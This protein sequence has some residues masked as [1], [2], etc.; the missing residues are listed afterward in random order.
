LILQRD[1]DRRACKAPFRK[2]IIG[3][4]NL[5]ETFVQADLQKT[6]IESTTIS[7]RLDELA[8]QITADYN[9]KELTVLAVLS[10]SLMFA[11][12][13]LRRI[14]L[15]LKLVFVSASSYHG[16]TVTTGN[17]DL[18]QIALP[19]VQGRHIL[20]IDDILDSGL[21]LDAISRRLREQEPQT[22]RICVLLRKQKQRLRNIDAD[23][24]GFDIGDEFVVGYGL[25]YQERYRNLP[26]IGV[27]KPEIIA[28]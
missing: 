9:G 8:A 26:F 22:V 13:L 12:D 25:D 16:G 18:G 3:T 21:T 14:P 15:A 5:G 6:L 4:L 24:V 23:Y 19:D 1:H 28:V 2:S 27:L 7:R 17:I 20:V 10:G 11:A